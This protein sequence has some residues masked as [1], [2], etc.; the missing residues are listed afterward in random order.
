MAF[1]AGLVAVS[2]VIFGW[3]LPGAAQP[4]LVKD[5]APG[6][7]E[8]QGAT[9]SLSGFT[10][11][12]SRAVF[13]VGRANETDSGSELWVTDGTDGGTERL[14]SFFG[15]N[16]KMAGGDGRTAFFFVSVLLFPGPASTTLWRTD[17]TAEGT[18]PLARLAATGE[19]LIHEGEL[20]FNGC[21]TQTDCEPWASD[22]TV[23]GTRRLRDIT[24]G[25]YG[26]D[27]HGFLSVGERLYFFATSPDGPGLWQTDLTRRGTRRVALLPF[28]FY[29]SYLDTAGGRLFFILSGQSSLWTSDGTAEGT[30]PV[31]PF[32]RPRGRGPQA[33]AL[34]GAVGDL[35]YFSGEDPVLGP[36][37]YRTDGTPGGTRRLTSFDH[38][39]TPFFSAV[40]LKDR[41]L[42]SGPGPRLWSSAGSRASTVPLSGCPE[43]CP[44]PL[45]GD[46]QQFNLA[47]FGGLAVFVG[48]SGKDVEPWVTDG[49]GA[50]TRRLLQVCADGH[51]GSYPQLG[52]VIHGR[53]LFAADQDLWSTD[54]TVAGTRK[55]GE[56]VQSPQEAP[57][58]VAAA[59]SWL[60]FAGFDESG[61][62]PQ[63]KASLGAASSQKVL[64]LRLNDGESS[65]PQSF[66]ALGDD[67]LFF[68]CA[69]SSGGI[70]RTRGTPETTVRLTDSQG[71]YCNSDVPQ[72]FAVAGGAA[73]FVAI[74]TGDYWSELWRTD[75]TP[76]GTRQV[77]HVGPNPYVTTLTAF[78]G[79]VVF[80]VEDPGDG[81]INTRTS[82]LWASDGTEAGT[83]PLFELP[84]VY[85]SGLRTFEGA[86]YF[87]GEEPGTFSTSLLR[88][89]GTA[90]GTRVLLPSGAG[91]ARLLDLGGQLFLANTGDLW[92]TDGTPE[93]THAITDGTGNQEVL[94]LAPLG[95]RIYFMG[96]SFPDPN[97]YPYRGTPT[98]FRSDGTRAATVAVR[99][100]A[101]DPTF[102]TPPPYFPRPQFTALAGSLFFVAWDPEHGAEL[103]R[104]DGTAAGTV[105]V[106]DVNPG[107]ASSRISGL[108]LVD[109]RLFF[110]ATDGEHGVELWTSDGTAAGTRRISDVAEG[111]L[112][113]SPRELAAIGGRLFFSADDQETG[114]EPWV[115]PLDSALADSASSVRWPSSPR[116]SSPG[117]PPTLTGEEGDARRKRLEPPLSRQGGGEAGREGVGGVRARPEGAAGP[118]GKGKP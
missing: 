7:F 61:S 27:P 97:D 99:T 118:S 74:R 62:I 94:D 1:R 76:E 23:A 56:G 112:S 70:W 87:Y 101:L 72:S 35:E 96:L 81:T 110:A 69:G 57:L 33:R 10:P 85:V 11:V 29:P 4:S 44:T 38:A 84:A 67:V 82:T 48:A 66:T 58:P 30:R 12:G 2:L 91:S 105:L 54:G 41:L 31:P 75:G 25:A 107:P 19:V 26:G 102:E 20:V 37:V 104:T 63:L 28:Y 55:V 98:L 80:V 3:A 103:W 39:P 60:V 95:G 14:R 77:T 71:F 86:L 49:T 88:S 22:G 92:R 108:T 15:L 32:D 115:L 93:G 43:G 109:G 53:L 106:D 6:V 13:L 79:K 114:R 17:G 89:D 46:F 65:N 111:P 68:S 8:P 24:P 78:Q 116:P 42:F 73:Y 117:L 18:F 47:A 51:C 113:S 9:S 5:V 45:L 21:A 90:A 64:D 34:L 40:P 59:G 100:F 36:Q 50:G 52:P 83:G 16:T